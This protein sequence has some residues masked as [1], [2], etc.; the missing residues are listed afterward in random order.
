MERFRLSS[1][2]KDVEMGGDID[3]VIA[4]DAQATV[5][6]LQAEKLML[7]RGVSA[8]SALIDGLQSQLIQCTA[9]LEALQRE[10]DEYARMW[11]D[12]CNDRGAAHKE[13]EDLTAALNAEREKVKGLEAQNTEWERKCRDLCLAHGPLLIEHHDVK[14]DLSQ[15]QAL[16]RALPVVRID[17]NGV[18]HDTLLAQP[19]DDAV[20]ELLRYR[21]SLDATTPDS[22]Q[23]GDINDMVSKGGDGE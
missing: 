6:A 23:L 4:A 8:Q 9:D 13:I 22:N 10:R 21:A 12:G 3:V 11:R 17:L 14:R 16:V 15:L 2:I 18:Y 19:E 1:L 5:E 7:E 20:K